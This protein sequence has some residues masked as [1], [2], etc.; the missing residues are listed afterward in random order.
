MANQDTT[1]YSID[2][3]LVYTYLDNAQR[4]KI[5]IDSQIRKLETRITSLTKKVNVKKAKVEKLDKDIIE[6]QNVLK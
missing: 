3:E 2:L 1:T 5:V 6:Y 4:E